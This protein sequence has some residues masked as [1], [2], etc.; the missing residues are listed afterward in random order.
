[1]RKKVKIMRKVKNETK[2][3]KKGGKMSILRDKK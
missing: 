3:N 1:M 2:V